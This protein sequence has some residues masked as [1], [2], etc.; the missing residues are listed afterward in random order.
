MNS[1]KKVYIFGLFNAFYDS[2]Y[3]KGI[4]DLYGKN[5]IVYD[6]SK[7][8][9]FRQNTFAAIFQHEDGKEIKVVID[10]RDT[11][12]IWK[13][14]L[15]WCDV[16]GKINYSLN[17]IPI[18][19]E[20][21]IIAIGPSFEIKFWNFYES[22]FLGIKHTLN[23]KNALSNRTDY[24]ANY[25]RQ[26]KRLRLEEYYSKVVSLDNYVFFVSSIWK[27]ESQTNR[28]RSNYIKACKSNSKIIF[29]GG[30]A[31]RK[32]G[33]NLGFGAL[34]ISKRFDLKAYFYKTKKTKIVFNTPAVLS[35][36]GWKLGEFLAMSKAIISTNHK[37]ILP[38]PL[39]NNIHIV[40]VDE[41]S[42]EDYSDKINKLI[43]DSEKRIELEANA[44]KYFKDHLEPSVVIK[45]LLNF[46]I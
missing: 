46:K 22:F 11:T 37:N 8:P 1:I 41:N 35:C 45:K 42:F 16:Y 23:F 31:P 14:E 19:F 17:E 20:F 43:D 15:V 26:Y 25:W 30:F 7:F 39:D 5:K 12:E 38:S 36:H 34:V 2:F 18:D 29:E 44:F 40:Y 32:D 10:S 27:K 24:F 13:E 21:K 4:Q 28:N 3:I 33:D 9:K 6:I